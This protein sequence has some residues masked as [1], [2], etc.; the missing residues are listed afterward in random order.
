[1]QRQIAGLERRLGI[2]EN[3]PS[4]TDLRSVDWDRTL[5]TTIIRVPSDA[6]VPRAA[7]EQHIGAFLEEA[8]ID[9]D[10]WTT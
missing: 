9:H 1:M 10:I 7:A 2:A 4:N 3:A 5:D 8:G 6:H